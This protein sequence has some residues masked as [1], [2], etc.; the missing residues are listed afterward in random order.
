MS[1]EI[2]QVRAMLAAARS[3]T[4]EERS[5]E[6][7]RTGMVES[8]A[9]MRPSETVAL[10]ETELAG[11]RTQT[12]T[13]ETTVPGRALLYFHGGGYVI[14]SPETH[15]GLVSYIAEAM[16]ATTWSV[17]YRLAPE[18]AFPAA[19]DDGAAAYAALLDTGIK[20]ENVIIA[21]D[22]AGGGTAVATAL[23]ARDDGYPMP[24]GLALL[25]PWVNLG[26]E[27]WSY[28]TRAEADPM[29]TEAGIKRMAA[30]YLDGADPAHPYASP[31]HADLEGLPP[32]LI[33][34]GPD[35]VLLSES[36]TLAERAGAAQVAVHLEIWPNMFHV[37]Q[38]LYPFLS[39][40]R[41]A[42]ARIGEWGA[43]QT[44]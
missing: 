1:S 29:I 8:T 41:K 2:E 38:A 15:T 21:G 42:I 25:S 39:D 14:G 33:Q 5:I 31:I 44:S 37:F 18:H 9:N 26:C 32:M 19:V 28:S 27:G 17:D 16:A 22:S 43:A 40:A 24:A 13:P 4:E 30:L 36:L 35:E 7:M 20:P 23:K 6:D 34:V 3:T 10:G 11:L 12:L